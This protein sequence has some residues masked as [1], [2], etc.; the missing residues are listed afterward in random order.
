ML[1]G[2]FP[3]GH[4]EPVVQRG[5]FVV[6]VGLKYKPLAFRAGVPTHHLPPS[7]ILTPTPHVMSGILAGLRGRWL[8][9]GT[10]RK[11]QKMARCFPW[12]A[13]EISLGLLHLTSQEQSFGK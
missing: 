10:I 9:C 1:A 13:W 11:E 4:E 5:E 12:L 2:M 3:F 6:G 8:V 7:H